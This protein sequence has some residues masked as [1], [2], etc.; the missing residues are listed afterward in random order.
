M[1]IVE[2]RHLDGIKGNFMVSEKEYLAPA[3]SNNTSYIASQIIYNN[4][5]EIVKQQN[6]IFDTLWNKSTTAN[7]AIKEI[8]EG[9]EPI[10]TRLLE[11]PDEIFNDLKYVIE[12]EIRKAVEDYRNDKMGQIWYAGR[13]TY[14]KGFKFKS[15]RLIS[16]SP[17]FL[18]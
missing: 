11:N 4:S 13:V 5:Q 14:L 7:T 1:K 16:L 15:G 8:G 10:G 17:V 6:Y 18:S 9:L 3:F 2:V 12:K